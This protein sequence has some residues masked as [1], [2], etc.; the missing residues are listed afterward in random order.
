MRCFFNAIACRGV[1][2]LVGERGGGLGLKSDVFFGLQVDGPVIGGVPIYVCVCVC[3]C[4]WG[5]GGAVGAGGRRGLISGSLLF[6]VYISSQVALLRGESK[7]FSCG[8]SLIAPD[9]VVTAAHCIAPGK[10]NYRDVWRHV[11][12]VEKFLDF[13]NLSWQ[14]RP[15]A[16]SNDGGKVWA[17]AQEL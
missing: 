1:N 11:T 4:V 3:V 2:I 12:M 5:G 15:F 6:T 9:W 14:K 8:G 16:L 17:T 10:V 7:V 13:N